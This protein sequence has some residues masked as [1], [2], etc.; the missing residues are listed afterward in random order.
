MPHYSAQI[1]QTGALLPSIV[2]VSNMRLAAIMNA[3]APLPN[4]V[5]TNLM[6]DTGATQSCLDNTHVQALGLQPTGLRQIAS[7]TSGS[8]ATFAYT[9]DVSLSLTTTAGV[10]QLIVPAMPVLGLNLSSQGIGG[11]IGRDLLAASRMLYCGPETVVLLS[12]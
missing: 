10:Q 4:P 9:Y 11:I 5:Q 3:N 8:T 7:A 6:I 12:L 1:G 2:F